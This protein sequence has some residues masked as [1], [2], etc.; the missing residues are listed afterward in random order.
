MS[1]DEKSAEDA[2]E[3]MGL[4]P[5]DFFDGSPIPTLAINADHVLTHF[6]HAC[7]LL[8]DIPSSEVIGRKD[9]GVRFYGTHRPILADLI[10][11]GAHENRIS[12]Y[13]SKQFRKSAAVPGAYEAEGFFPKIGPR[14]RW[15]FFTAAPLKNSR[16]EVVG[17]IETLQDISERRRA[18]E[19]L[20]VAWF[21]VERN[22]AQ[23]T[24]ELA[25]ANE[26]L[27]QNE[28]LASIG[29]LAAG[30]AHEINNPIGYIFS[31]FGMLEEYLKS[32]F[33]MLSA[34]EKVE[35]LCSDEKLRAEITEKYKELDI[36]FLKQDLPNLMKESREG[37]ER[38]RKIVQDLKDFSHIDSRLDW[39]LCNL[40]QGIESTLNVVNNEVKYKADVVKEFADL[41]LVQCIPSQINQVILNLLVNAAHSMGTKRGL[42]HIRTGCDEQHVWI[43][44][45]DNGSG[46]PKDVVP[47]IFEPFYTTKPVGQGTGL[48]LSLSYG[49]VQKHHGEITLNTELG[50]GTTFRVT[51]PISQSEDEIQDSQKVSE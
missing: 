34:Y 43:E 44:V 4:H 10:V 28:K 12:E 37:I 32:I 17:A 26:R 50:V 46:I 2:S 30:V 42:I 41:P 9:I 23:R 49:I 25:I 40:Y 22:V 47:R 24:K 13:Y 38:V 27:V 39:Q 14:G 35:H 11:D 1:D 7:A 51:L 18:E 6:N 15:L 20:K 29:Q 33:E 31:N 16:G 19:S 48:G 21:E 5:S 36:D 3:L 45:Q 8:L